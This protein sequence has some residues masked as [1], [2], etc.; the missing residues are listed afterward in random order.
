MHLKEKDIPSIE[1][2]VDQAQG[3]DVP[4]ILQWVGQF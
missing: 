3:Q 1:P 2:E 4:I